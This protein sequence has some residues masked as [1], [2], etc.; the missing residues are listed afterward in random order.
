MK[1]TTLVNT[2]PVIKVNKDG[3]IIVKVMKGNEKLKFKETDS[4][5]NI[6]EY[7]ND[8]ATL[9]TTP[10]SK[11]DYSHTPNIILDNDTS[12]SIGKKN[13]KRI[14]IVENESL[15][16]FG[17]TGPDKNDETIKQLINAINSNKIE[18]I[19]VYCTKVPMSITNNGGKDNNFINSIGS[20]RLVSINTK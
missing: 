14:M 20:I 8:F 16:G 13:S 3:N 15:F 19:Q 18:S 1:Y 2:K 11:T 7:D 6:G 5:V 4:L 17:V 12:R 10:F 9:P